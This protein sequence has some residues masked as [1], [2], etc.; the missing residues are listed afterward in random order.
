MKKKEKLKMVIDLS[1]TFS[2]TKDNSQVIPRLK[3][4]KE[5]IS[6][7]NIDVNFDVPKTAN[8]VPKC[9]CSTKI[10]MTDLCDGITNDRLCTLC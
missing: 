4:N 6:N 9:A 8:P 10:N 3:L 2:K 5:T 1:L 7:L